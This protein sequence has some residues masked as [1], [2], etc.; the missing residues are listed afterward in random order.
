MWKWKSLSSA[1]LFGTQ[2]WILKWVA[3][4]F[5][6]GS[7]QPRNWNQVSRIADGFF[8]VWATREAHESWSG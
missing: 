4:P 3:I 5:A 8:T 6:R 2:A 7:S 1:K